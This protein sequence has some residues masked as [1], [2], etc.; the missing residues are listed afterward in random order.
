LA[1][2]HRQDDV[3][4]IDAVREVRPPF[5]PDDV[6]V[7]FSALL[8]SYR[9]TKV[10]GDRYA[11]EWP[12]ERFRERDIGYEPAERPKSDLYRD[13][14][15]LINARRIDLLD[16]KRL[17]AQFLGLERRTSR[18]GKDSIDH[19]P[20]GLDD[21]ANAAAGA[22][23]LLAAESSYWRDNMAWVGDCSRLYDQQPYFQR[24]GGLPWLR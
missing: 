21:L 9:V 11:G 14:L 19:G 2:A 3:V 4:V 24:L 8:K 16:D 6:V 7:G 5:I 10:S 1:V 12:R 20:G 13:V 23:G 15:P 22:A 18:A 17:A